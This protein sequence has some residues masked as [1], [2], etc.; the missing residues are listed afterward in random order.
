MSL[1]YYE[2]GWYLVLALWLT[3][4][5]YGASFLLNYY[6][7]RHVFLY[8]PNGVLPR[9][10]ATVIFQI[11]ALSVTDNLGIVGRGVSSIRK[12]ASEMGLR[13]YKVV[14]VSDDPRDAYTHADADEAI[15]VPDSYRCNAVRKARSLNYAAE[16]YQ[17]RFPD[18]KN[19][20]IFHID[21]ESVVL[22]QTVEAIVKYIGSG[23]GLLAEGPSCS[24][25]A[26]PRMASR[27]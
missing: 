2:L 9:I 13:S 14:T 18:L 25:R 6:R 4:L 19:V 15:V 27:A 24:R 21:E 5:P 23:D 10:G 1:S 12:S 26:F 20:W 7:N 8:K 3:Y 11:T 22:P 16:Q 17:Q